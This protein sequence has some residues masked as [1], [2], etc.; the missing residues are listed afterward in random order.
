MIEPAL[1]RGR[2]RYE[3]VTTGRVDNTHDDAFT[4]TVR[5]EDPDRALEVAIVATPSPDY[6]I[7]AARCRVERGEVAA[8]VA[9]G[10]ARLAGVAMVGGLT[11]RVMEAAGG[12]AGAAL[13]V[14]AVVEAAR[15]ARQVAKFPRER[16]E[17]AAGGDPWECWQLDTTGW[18]DLP[19]SCFTYSDAGRALF[20]TRTIATPMQPD[21][22]SPRPGQRGVFERRK[23]ARLER[24]DGRLALFHSMHDNCHG[25]EITY[26]I[27]AAGRIVKAE[28][29]TPRLPYMGICSEPQRKIGA[30]LGEMVDD[31]LR[32]RIQLHLG[33]PTGCAQLYDLTADLLKLLAARA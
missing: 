4:H 22:Y 18:V 28:H 33:G 32:R 8:S 2:D 29:L 13:A 6:A 26:E 24:R 30:L 11:R 17:R 14:D 7:R 9:D 16:A 3:R 5:L 20:G 25:F 1:L 15:L 23:V 19:D 27:D 12:G 10:V 31:G 21:L